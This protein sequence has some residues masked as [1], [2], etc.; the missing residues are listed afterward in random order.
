MKL[1]I[2]AQFQNIIPLFK[3]YMV[4]IVTIIFGGMYGFLIIS[5][6]NQAKNE[7]PEGMVLDQVSATDRP[8]ID[9][10]A[11]ASLQQLQDQNIEVRSLFEEA[12]NN[13]FAE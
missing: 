3:K 5:S 11:A 9:Q 8:S 4:V 13:P 12:R 6:S 10:S 7:P 1:D 2:N